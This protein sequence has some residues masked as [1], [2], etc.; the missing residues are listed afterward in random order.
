MNL[1]VTRQGQPFFLLLFI[2][3]I[4]LCALQMRADACGSCRVGHGIFG[5]SGWLHTLSL[6]HQTQ[7]GWLIATVFPARRLASRGAT[8][9]KPELVKLQGAYPHSPQASFS[10]FSQ[11]PSLRYDRLL[12]ATPQRSLFLLVKGSLSRSVQTIEGK[13]IPLSVGSNDEPWWQDGED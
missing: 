8:F 2:Q 6:I 7:R 3:R 12:L 5:P 10:R 11:S 1:C 13:L 9:T 4:D